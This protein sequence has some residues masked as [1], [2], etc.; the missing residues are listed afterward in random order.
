MA[1]AWYILQTY[2]QFENRVERN[3]R[4]LMEEGGP[5]AAGVF[6]G[7]LFVIF[8]NP[9]LIVASSLIGASLILRDLRL[10]PLVRIF[11]MSV[12]CAAGILIQFALKKE[13]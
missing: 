2:S 10:E 1:R 12:L 13:G 9:A 7:I 6:G 3:I 11:W 4:L 5:L 8:F